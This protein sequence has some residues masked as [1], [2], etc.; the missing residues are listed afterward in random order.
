MARWIALALVVGLGA[1]AEA[2]G[3]GRPL[4][5]G[6]S[7][8]AAKHPGDKGIEKDPSTVFAE[9]F[10][11]GFARRVEEVSGRR[12]PPRNHVL[13]ARRAAAEPG[14]AVAPDDPRRRPG[15]RCPPLPPPPPRLRQAARPLL[16]QVRPR[17]RADP[18]FLPRRRL[19]SA[20]PL[21]GRVAQA[22]GLGATNGSPPASSRSASPGSGISTATGWRCAAARP[23]ANLG[24][25]VRQ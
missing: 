22:F 7:G 8:I 5:E 23:G 4:P 6:D 1:V 10:E 12:E 25:L 2:A 16:R 15:R 13:L 9:L 14:Q 24:Q 18:P 21:G 20:H 3:T 17:L 19:Q 11:S